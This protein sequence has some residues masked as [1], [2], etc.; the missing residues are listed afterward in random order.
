M[1]IPSELDGLTPAYLTAALRESGV[2]DTSA[3]AAAVVDRVPAGSGFAGQSAHLRLTYDH[4]GDGAPVT[5]FAKLSASDPAVLTRLKAFGLYET[6][7]GFYR[8]LSAEAPLRC[9]GRTAL[10]DAESGGTLVLLEEIGHLRFGDNVAGA[11]IDDAR[12]ALTSLARLQAH[13]WNRPRLSHC[14]W[15]R[16]PVQD[17]VS[18]A[19]MLRALGPVWEQRWAATATPVATATARA[20]MSRYEAWIDSHLAGP[21]TLSHGDFRPDNMAFTPE[22]EMVLFDWQTSRFDAPSRDV[23]YFLAFALSTD[24]RRQHEAA[25]LALYHQALVDAGVRDYTLDDVRANH[26]RSVGS[27]VARMI[28]AGAMLDFSSERG[29][30]LA[31]AIF[32]RVAAMAEDHDFLAWCERL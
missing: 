31:H 28:S 22:G 17:R 12:T 14:D 15:L 16:T 23:A 24:V 10:Y 19:P 6:E 20:L 21:R 4:D 13:Y 27:A 9:R 11:S 30:K 25:L 2:L 18:L 29:T 7:A 32:S 5:M 3:V 1:P 26:R 8:D